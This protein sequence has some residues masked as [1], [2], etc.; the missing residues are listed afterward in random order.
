MKRLIID[1]QVFHTQALHRGM[2][3]YSLE[4]LDA[5]IRQNKTGHHWDAIELIVSSKM[6]LSQEANQLLAQKAKDATITKLPLGKDVIYSARSVMKRN[7]AVIDGYV[8]R[9]RSADSSAALDFFILSPLQGGISSVFPS[10]DQVHKAAIC[11]DLIPYMFHEIYFRNPIARIENLTKLTEFLK[12]DTYLAISK[13]VANDLSIYLGADPKQVRNIDGGPINHSKKHKPY[14]VTR[15]FILMPTGNDIRKNNRMGVLGFNEFNKM[16]GD[17]YALVVTSFFDP[18]QIHELSE[19]ASN[20]IFTG[21]IS[22][23]ELEY[24]Y[25]NCEALLFPSEYEG[26]GLPVLEAIQKN[27]PVACSDIA[28]FREMSK[29]AFSYFDP[30]LG[31]SIARALDDTLKTKVDSRAY[32]NILER[33]EWERSA[34]LMIAAFETSRAH[35]ENISALEKV[36]IFVQNP[37]T[38]DERAR[39]VQTAYEAVSRQLNAMYYL[40]GGGRGGSARASLLHYTENAVT[41][42]PGAPIHIK[43][44]NTPIYYLKN[45]PESAHILFAAL[46]HPGV[47]IIDDLELSRAWQMLRAEGLIGEERLQVEQELQAQYGDESTS[48]LCSAVA[49]QKAI[50]VYSRQAQKA[51][52]TLLRKMDRQVPVQILTYPSAPLVYDDTL[53]RKTETI[54]ILGATAGGAEHD[55]FL[56]ASTGDFRKESIASISDE[57]TSDVKAHLVGVD[58][59]FEDVLSRTALVYAPDNTHIPTLYSAMRYGAV[60]IRH[61]SMRAVAV[62]PPDHAITIRT[63][64]DLTESV[65]RLDVSG[66]AYQKLSKMVREELRDHTFSMYA[67]QLRG[68]VQTANGGRT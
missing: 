58:R 4:L 55:L 46:A 37:E 45:D 40:Q 42:A 60:P 66:E 68:L 12:A 62:E 30:T 53:P 59:T 38:N 49:H 5:V 35:K 19:L 63:T 11:Y 57:S 50:G 10:D 23:G 54:S 52:Q 41:I 32:A 26:L 44:D 36:A 31:T 14:P 9:I 2:G 39:M 64:K 56:A 27:R 20:V 3:K 16:H 6:P 13:T 22:G 1:A 8:R 7:R 61:A 67:Q 25:A 48:M 28:V 34:H 15:P 51:V 47:V 17:R 65:S 18:E 21:N 24:L 43:K 33:Y 29:T